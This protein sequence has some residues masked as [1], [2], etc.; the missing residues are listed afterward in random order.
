MGTIFVVGIFIMIIS[1]FIGKKNGKSDG[2]THADNIQQRP[3]D[4]QAQSRFAW[5]VYPLLV[6]VFSIGI[7]FQV[8]LKVPFAYTVWIIV[9]LSCLIV[10][11]AMRMLRSETM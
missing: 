2:H 1:F 3:E 9:G 8:F 10:D 5:R 4:R 11:R 7:A 6:T